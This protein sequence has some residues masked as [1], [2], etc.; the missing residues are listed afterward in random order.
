MCIMRCVQLR[1]STLLVAANACRD[2]H[3]QSQS[4]GST[5]ENNRLHELPWALVD[6]RRKMPRVVPEKSNKEGKVFPTCYIET[7]IWKWTV[8]LRVSE[9]MNRWR[10]TNVRLWK[11]PNEEIKAPRNR[12]L[13]MRRPCKLQSILQNYPCLTARTSTTR[14]LQFIIL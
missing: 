10:N 12:C 8:R 1:I 4:M 5:S 9:N 6:L 11:W 2:K 7:R 14:V 13:L 3:G